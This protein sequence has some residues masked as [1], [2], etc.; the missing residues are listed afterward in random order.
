MLRYI[1][2]CDFLN[3]DFQIDYE[4]RIPY[5]VYLPPD[6]PSLSSALSSHTYSL[7]PFLPQRSSPWSTKVGSTFRCRR[8]SEWLGEPLGENVFQS[9]GLAGDNCKFLTE[10]GYVGVYPELSLF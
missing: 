10:T 4:S 5:L 9:G 7:Y 1:D 8:V 6:P 3:N 2:R